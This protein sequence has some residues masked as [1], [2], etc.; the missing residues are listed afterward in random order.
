MKPRFSFFVLLVFLAPLG[1]VAFAGQGGPDPRAA[2]QQRAAGEEPERSPRLRFD[3][4]VTVTANRRAEDLRDVGSSVTVIGSEQIA[5]SG[6]RWLYD[7]LEQAPGVSVVRGGPVGSATTVFLRGTNSNHTLFLIDGVKV[8]SP[9]TGAYDLAHLQI[10]ADQIDRIEIVRGPQSP[11]YGSEAIGGV[12]NVITKRGSGS[13]AY[14]VEADGGSYRTGRVHLFAN[15][16]TDALHYSGG[17][18]Y[19]DTNGF[20]AA[21]ENRGNPEN[22]GYRNASY[23]ARLGYASSSGA[24]VDGFVRG[25]S[26]EGGFDDFAF[27]VGPIDSDVN[28]QE[29]NDLYAAVTAGYEGERFATSLTLSDSETALETDTPE[30]F[31]TAFAL[32]ASIR[33]MDWQNEIPAP[34]GQTLIG[35]VEYRRERADVLS[36]GVTGD[37]G[38]D[39]TVEVVGAYLHDRI[40]LASVGVVTVGGRFEDHSRF[41]SKWTFRAAGTGRVGANARLHGSIGSGFRAPSLNDLFFPF[42]GNSELLPEENIGVDVGLEVFAARPEVRVDATYFRNDIDNLIEFGALGFENLGGALTQGLEVVGDWSPARAVVV[43]ASYT[44]TDAVSRADQKQLARRPRHQGGLRATLD[45]L[46]A[47]RFFAELRAKSERFDTGPD[48]RVAL[49]GFA[50][51]NLAGSYRIADSVSLRGRVDNLFDTEYEEIF[52]FGTAGLSA[53]VGVTV[54]VTR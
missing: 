52:G 51:V 2:G 23:R 39:E 20:S 26:A 44:Y 37:S 4:I 9:S 8:N 11:L 17:L 16:Q 43:A 35:G 6:A 48:G 33:E 49:D 19:F 25:F 54:S 47:L 32:D 14:G 3:E 24:F 46:D 28:V 29:S 10:A 27:G 40:E 22:D 12:I 1:A 30:G 34:P 13:G 18:S 21:S 31:F 5:A 41:G 53:Y 15:G 42:F 7:L 36:R 45:P 38:F 50:V